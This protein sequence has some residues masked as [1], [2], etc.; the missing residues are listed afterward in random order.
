MGTTSDSNKI[1]AHLI[2][3]YVFDCLNST[4]SFAHEYPTEACCEA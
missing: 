4:G 2:S 3:I 1:D